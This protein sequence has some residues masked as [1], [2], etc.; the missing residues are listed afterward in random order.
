MKIKSI[1][2]AKIQWR[3]YRYAPESFRC[4]VNGKE[5]FLENPSDLGILLVRGK[6]KEA[7][8]EIKRII[9]KRRK[10]ERLVG[11]GFRKANNPAQFLYTSQLYARDSDLGEKLRIYKEWKRFCI[12]QNKKLTTH[13]VTTGEVTPYGSEKKS[14]EKT[15]DTVDLT[16]PVKFRFAYKEELI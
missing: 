8:D 2:G 16:K 14:E 13:I 1:K 15:K 3:M 9:R 6:Q 5:L 12:E 11:Y 4:W 10:Q 7:H